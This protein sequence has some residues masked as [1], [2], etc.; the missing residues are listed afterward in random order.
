MLTLWNVFSFFATYA[1][2][3]E[4]AA[5]AGDDQPT[6]HV[7]DRWVLSELDDTVRVV[8]D[9]LEG[10]DALEGATRLGR[11]VDDLSNWYVRRSRPRFW[12]NSDPAAHATL[13]EAL[14][15]L[16][17]LLA[18][19]V[20]FIADEIY[21]TLTGEGSV[22]ASDWPEPKGRYDATLATQMASARR[23]VAIGRAARTDA[24]VKVRQPLAR[25]LMLHPGDALSAELQQEIRTELNVKELEDIDTLSGLLSWTVLPN[26]RVLGP[27]LG[28]KI[29]EVKQALATAD[30]SALHD[31]LE[32][33]GF[34]EV[35]GERLERDDVEV[36]AQRHEAFALSEDDGW[37]VA[38][39]LELDDE[40]RAEGLARELVR[41]LN[42][43]RKERGF[44]I[45]DRIAVRIDAPA[46]LAASV[47]VH[48]DWIAGE[49]LATT[50]LL[51]SVDDDRTFDVDG[52][53]VRVSLVKT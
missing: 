16:S 40:L 1:D 28:P 34:V 15:T 29:N 3:D 51:E 17:Q 20:P 14:V 12:K 26:F 46:E 43:L 42:D 13:H 27:R 21:T 49:V 9:A 36:R 35:A 4:W 19:F 7:L 31:Q 25:A 5:E 23:L 44:E 18:P 33:N 11:F 53:A 32:T 8:T 41:A 47:S 30:G 6:E 39:D 37:A 38:L 50:L 48:T 45:A 10:F 22:H 24:K 2:L 52:H